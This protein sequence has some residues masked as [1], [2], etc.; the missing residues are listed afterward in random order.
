[1]GADDVKQGLG[2]ELK[3]AAPGH[4]HAQGH[5]DEH[6]H[7][8]AAQGNFQAGPDVLEQRGAVGVGAALELVNK[9]AENF[10]RTGKHHRADQMQHIGTKLPD[11]QNKQE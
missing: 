3:P 7:R 10:G 5:A 6:A 2:K 11:Q 8:I 4:A 9:G 1:M